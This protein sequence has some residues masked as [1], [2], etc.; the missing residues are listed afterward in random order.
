MSIVWEKSRADK[1]DETDLTMAL[2]ANHGGDSQ[3]ANQGKRIENQQLL[4]SNVPTLTAVQECGDAS[5]CD[6]LWLLGS[7]LILHPGSTARTRGNR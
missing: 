6:L 7:T 4:I 2:V 5:E 1:V 3:V